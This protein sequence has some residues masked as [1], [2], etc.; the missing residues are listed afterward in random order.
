MS[1]PRDTAAR[2]L[3]RLLATLVSSA[4]VATAAVFAVATHSVNP[5]A[6]TA[7]TVANPITPGNFTGYGFDQC[8]A[9]SQ[10]AMTTWRKS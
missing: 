8:N 3:R 4:L 6:D 10:A 5:F 1:V 2:R 7:A 9:P